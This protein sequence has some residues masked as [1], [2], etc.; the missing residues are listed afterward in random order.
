M[1]F[2]VWFSSFHWP[3]S[4]KEINTLK[5]K[6][7]SWIYVYSF[8]MNALSC[9][10]C[11]HLLLKKPRVIPVK[12]ASLFHPMRCS[13][14]CGLLRIVVSP[15]PPHSQ[16]RLSLPLV[17]NYNTNMVLS[18]SSLIEF[19]W[20]RVQIFIRKNY[21]LSLLASLWIA[22]RTKG[23]V[24][25]GIRLHVTQPGRIYSLLLPSLCSYL[26]KC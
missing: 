17:I 25:N 19:W 20:P 4:R 12:T 13:L 18:C 5:K 24:Q 14:V 26:W 21:R 3:A 6:K 9:Q 10:D 15:Q 22:A 7:S 11:C 2:A 23:L 1:E 8:R 16:R